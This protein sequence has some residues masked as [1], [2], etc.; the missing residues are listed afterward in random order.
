MRA[1][2]LR[3]GLLLL[4]TLAGVAGLVLLLAGDPFRRTVGYETYLRES[5]QGL[6]VGAAVRFRGVTLG[7]VTAIE[8]ASSEYGQ[9]VPEALRRSI[10]L[11]AVHFA[12]DETRARGLPDIPQAV[13]DGLRARLATP[14]LT[15]PA[16]LELDFADPARFPPETLAW[17][18]RDTYIPAMP[19]TLAV[20]R[21][22]AEHLLGQLDQV[23]L[24]G[25][26]NGLGALVTL[27]RTELG[28]T[29]PAGGTGAG[30]TSQLHAVIAQ[31]TDTLRL[32]ND[33]LR[34]AD[35]PGLA[36]TVRRTAGDADALLRGRQVHD[37]LASATDA[38]A[39]LDAIAVRLPPLLATLQSAAGRADTGAADLQSQLDPILHD[40]RAA[41]RD[42]R[43]AGDAARRDPAQL[44][45][46]G[47]PPRT[48]GR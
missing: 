27:L 28:G 38:A 24:A 48:L 22:G 41:V 31:A 21:N 36:S 12:L 18:P 1:L 39:R 10:F 20:V 46:G 2:Q 7:R 11:V 8:L 15:G 32:A 34:A 5:V 13:R 30:G 37:L 23:D 40:A 43:E 14:G 33:T 6:D 17:T 3:V 4:G 45:L 19:S 9:A 44:I 25:L 16:Y 42:L 35:L 29:G 47:P 26:A